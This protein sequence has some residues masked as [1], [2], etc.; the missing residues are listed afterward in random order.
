[1][2][3]RTVLDP[4]SYYSAPFS[5]GRRLRRS[6]TSPA[7][8][9]TAI[10]NREAA[11]AVSRL[12]RRKRPLFMVVDQFAPHRSGGPS[13][14]ERCSA[15]GPEPVVADANAFADAPLPRPASFNEPDA[16]DKPSFIRAREPYDAGEV[17]ALEATWRCTLASLLGVDRG[18]ARIWRELGRI[19]ERRNTMLAFTSDNGLYFGEHRLSVEKTAPYRESVEVPLAIR[20]PPRL[21]PPGRRG[22][23]VGEL[24]GNADLPATILDVADAEPCRSAGRC[25]TLDG[26]SLL[27]PAAGRRA[28]PAERA[29]PLEL[30]TAGEPADPFSPCAYRGFVTLGEVYVHHT[31][32]AGADRSCA[33]VDDYERYD[34]GSDP[35]QLENLG[36]GDPLGAAALAARAE[37]LSE[38]AGIRGR[39][40]RSGGR[41]FC[42]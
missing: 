40:R 3:W 16:S 32:A 13:R 42:E 36:A 6:G 2:R 4:T 10:I 37:R 8:H 15:P 27:A 28:L 38:C 39:D 12:G 35:L 26:R 17:A 14:V 22:R 34:L 24:V 25:R 29:I 1:M 30:D 20:F 33:P 11:E 23:P 18:F 9:T 5:D 31:S 21:V 19:G 41:P 7:Q